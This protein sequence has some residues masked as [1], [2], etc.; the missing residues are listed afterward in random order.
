MRRASMS[1]QSGALMSSR[2]IPPKVE[3][4]RH[5]VSTKRSG[6]FV[7]MRIGIAEMPANW[8]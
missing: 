8:R 5:T 2:W 3:A 6:S 1:K 4:I 7:S